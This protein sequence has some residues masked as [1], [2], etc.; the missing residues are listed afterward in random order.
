MNRLV[1]IGNGFDLAH[2]LPTSYS[3]F[4][5]FYWSNLLAH[6]KTDLEFS[7]ELVEIKFRD[8]RLPHY[9]K[10]DLQNVTSYFDLMD[11]LTKHPK[12]VKIKINN[13][14]NLLSE[15]KAIKNWVEIEMFYYKTLLK[16]SGLINTES[17]NYF[18][19]I[20]T[21]NEEFEIIKGEFELYLQKQV[22]SIWEADSL[23]IDDLLLGFE[24]QSFDFDNLIQLKDEL[25]NLGY[26]KFEENLTFKTSINK[27]VIN[28]KCNFLSFNYTTTVS[29][30]FNLIND[31]GTLNEI[32]GRLNSDGNPINFGFGDE[33]DENYQRIERLDDNEYLKNFK[34]FQYL[35]TRNYKQ[36]LD[37][38]D[39]DIFQVYIM[40]HSCGLSDRTLLNTIFEHENCV[41]IKVFYHQWKNESTDKLEDNYTEIT[42]NISRHFNDKKLMREK[43][44]NKKLCHPMPQVQLP[45]IEK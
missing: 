45:K 11:F 28:V 10:T 22:E 29:R 19:N 24:S 32:H 21:L 25:S 14:F 40:G 44:V 42:Q 9:I 7:D 1:I 3:N 2:G 17:L 4:I 26:K 37:L 39:S 30:Y 8:K 15:S 31:K 33:M 41:S 13:F 5:D 43:V 35:H 36:L 20:S 6:F 16:V 38:I 34:S 12:E 27:R 18:E 23:I